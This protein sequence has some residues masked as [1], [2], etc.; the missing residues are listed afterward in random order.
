MAN[1]DPLNCFTLLVLPATYICKFW[2]PILSNIENMAKKLDEIHENE[3]AY[4]TH[5]RKIDKKS[6]HIIIAWSHE[7]MKPKK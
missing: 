6:L 1:V 2:Q 3:S 4:N 7:I 5:Y